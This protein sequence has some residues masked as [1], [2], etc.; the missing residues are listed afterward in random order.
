MSFSVTAGLQGL[1]R[2][3]QP[4]HSAVAAACPPPPPAACGKREGW[5]VVE[6]GVSCGVL[7]TIPGASRAWW[8]REAESLLGGAALW[9]QPPSPGMEAPP[10]VP[11]LPVS[12][13]LRSAGGQPLTPNSVWQ[14][15]G[16]A[17][18]LTRDL[19]RGLGPGAV[20]LGQDLCTKCPLHQPPLSCCTL[21]C[22]GFV[23]W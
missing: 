10:A 13:S 7:C 3:T 17:A 20:P 11:R 22:E 4:G 8:D 18:G 19:P 14:P 9:A 21:S 16:R 2:G 6:S 12:W 23:F 5:W 15:A 1:R